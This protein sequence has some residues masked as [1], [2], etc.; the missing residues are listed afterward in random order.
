MLDIIKRF[1]KH[2]TESDSD[3]LPFPSMGY[4]CYPCYLTFSSLRHTHFCFRTSK[5]LSVGRG[6]TVIHSGLKEVSYVRAHSFCHSAN[7]D[8]YQGMK[9]FCTGPL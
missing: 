3:P 5:F 7:G 8:L 9:P 2:K 1:N 4:K 6:T